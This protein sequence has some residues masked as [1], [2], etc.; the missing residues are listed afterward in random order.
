M[1]GLFGG[2]VKWWNTP[3]K[4]V[5]AMWFYIAIALVVT[6]V[7]SNYVLNIFWVAT[8]MHPEITQERIDEQSAELGETIGGVFERASRNLMMK[9]KEYGEAS[10]NN[11][12]KVR[13]GMRAFVYSLYLLVAL[14]A[15]GIVKN[16]WHEVRSLCKNARRK[17]GGRS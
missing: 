9:G 11:P 7:L 13:W 12:D 2:L 6:L 17:R 3:P 16:I 8:A 4:K 5:S 1:S 15:L 10:P 14:L